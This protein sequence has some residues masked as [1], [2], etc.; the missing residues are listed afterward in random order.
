MT[1]FGDLLR[2]F[3]PLGIPMGMALLGIFLRLLYTVGVEEGQQSAWRSA[4]YFML[5]MAVPY[6]SFYSTILPTWIRM[7][8]MLLLGGAVVNF[9]VRLQQHRHRFFS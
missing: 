2:N 7:V 1:V 8:F 6:E 4:A 9:L 3:G 5:L